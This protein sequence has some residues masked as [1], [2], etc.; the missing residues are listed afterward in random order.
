MD[1]LNDTLNALKIGPRKK[2]EKKKEALNPK[3]HNPGDVII[4]SSPLPEVVVETIENPIL[5]D[6]MAKMNITIPKS[7]KL[8]FKKKCVACNTD[9]S[10][11]V[12]F[13]VKQFLSLH[14]GSG[15]HHD[16]N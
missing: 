10:K 4:E 5:E 2:K 11:M 9:M 7:L 12:N 14:P 8:R 3:E 13:W 16:E 6:E 1:F 15:A